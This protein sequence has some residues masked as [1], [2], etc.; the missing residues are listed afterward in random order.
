MN[1]INTINECTKAENQ[2]LS[3]TNPD[4]NIDMDKINSL[5]GQKMDT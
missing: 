2:S 4:L 5:K 1:L 3:I